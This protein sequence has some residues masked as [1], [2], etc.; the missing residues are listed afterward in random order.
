MS[1]SGMAFPAVFKMGSEVKAFQRKERLKN[2]LVILALCGVFIEGCLI[3]HLWMRGPEQVNN[4]NQQAEKMTQE[5]SEMQVMQA[6]LNRK[7]P[8][9]HVTGCKSSTNEDGKLCWEP[10]D[11]DAFTHDISY[12]NGSLVIKHKGHYFIYSKIFYGETVCTEKVLFN[13]AIMRL[14]Q[15]FDGS[16]E[17][18]KSKRYHCKNPNEDGLAN[19]FLGGVYHLLEGDQIFVKVEQ[20]QL[21]L[22]QSSSENYF[23]A[24]LI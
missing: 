3:Y 4:I 19:S 16:L 6:Q 21:I 15:M 20:N 22:L 12:K 1:G 5:K 7:K 13:H 17:L 18:M 23:G 2:L 8:A 10:L 24:F 14:T 9:A 11:G